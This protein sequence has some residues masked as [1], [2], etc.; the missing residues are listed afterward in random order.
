MPRDPFD[1]ADL[2]RKAAEL[3]ERAT[4]LILEAELYERTAQAKEALSRRSAS[5]RTTDSGTVGAEATLRAAT[6]EQ[7]GQRR[8]RIA[9]AT[10]KNDHPFP[11]AV[12]ARYLSVA[13]WAEKHGFDAKSV[14]SWYYGGAAARS[15][16]AHAAE[17]IAREFPELPATDETW[18]NG[19]QRRRKPL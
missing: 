6:T 9:S 7:E 1:P 15:I 14:R 8:Q 11:R 2:R 3:R 17:L 4:Q 10:L 18:P 12:Q 5:P 19:I 13:D 16:P